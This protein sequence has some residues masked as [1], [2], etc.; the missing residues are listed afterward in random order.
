MTSLIGGL[1]LAACLAQA[2]P[3]V[4]ETTNGRLEVVDVA[5]RRIVADGVTWALSS[6][7]VVQVP[8][9]KRAR[10][11]DLRPGLNVRMTMVPVD[12]ALPVVSRITV[13]PD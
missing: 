10:L 7:L 12:G 9:L 1:L 4:P 2:A 5:S 11:R 3:A 8:G 6:T 13:L